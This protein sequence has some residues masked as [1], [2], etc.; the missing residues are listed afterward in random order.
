MERDKG[1]LD[2]SFVNKG[3]TTSYCGEEKIKAGP[4]TRLSLPRPADLMAAF[5]LWLS[6]E[7]GVVGGRPR[8][9]LGEESNTILVRVFVIGKTHD[10][11]RIAAFATFAYE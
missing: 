9:F 5:L 1:L 6:A 8:I 4:K 11:R 3:Q 7:Y 10:L 2:G